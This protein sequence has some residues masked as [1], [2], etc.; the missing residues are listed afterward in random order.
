MKETILVLQGTGALAAYECGVYKALDE[1]GIWPDVVAG[2]S[3]GAVNAAI[4]ASHPPGKAARAMEEF[5]SEI[6]VKTPAFPVEGLRRLTASFQVLMMGVPNCFMPRWLIPSW[7]AWWPA[8]WASFYDRRP[9][10]RLL[11]RHVDFEYLPSSKT[12]LILMAVNVETG[13]RE[14]FDSHT[15]PIAPEHIIA[16]GSLPPEF[17]WMQIDG[18]VYWDGA[19]ASSTPLWPVLERMVM[20][21]IRGK[22]EVKEK[23]VYL[24]DQP[25]RVKSRP[26]NL[27]EVLDRQKEILYADKIQND[28]RSCRLVNDALVLIKSLLAKIS[29]PEARQVRE[30]Q[31]YKRFVSQSCWVDVTRIDPVDEAKELY[32]E[33]YDFSRQSIQKHQELGYKKT[34]EL[35]AKEI[36]DVFH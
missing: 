9:L 7:N 26:R 22:T 24:V 25:A 16:S 12:R 29:D 14:V 4:I 30:G 10:M 28:I 19:L 8:G 36:S 15:G 13:E 18:R 33:G 35:L 6:G 17:P 20:D 34:H 2:V 32:Y 31:V 5:W 21:S 23:K 3:M 1:K 11:K 27:L